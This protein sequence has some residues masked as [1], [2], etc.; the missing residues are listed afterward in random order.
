MSEPTFGATGEFPDGKLVEHDEGELRCGVAGDPERH[1][2]FIDFGSPVKSLGMSPDQAVEFAAS[3][4][5]NAEK[6]RG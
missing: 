1:L 5:K 6:A 2:V 3:I 4:L